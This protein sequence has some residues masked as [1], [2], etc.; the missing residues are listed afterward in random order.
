MKKNIT[1]EWLQMQIDKGKSSLDVANTLDISKSS[2]LRAA[3]E[4]GIKF[5]GKSHWRN[6]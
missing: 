1:K 4:L 3:Q 2:V 5:T 6:K